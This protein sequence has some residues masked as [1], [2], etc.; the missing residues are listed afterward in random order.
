LD[1]PANDVAVIDLIDTPYDL[2]GRDIVCYPNL[3]LAF[4]IEIPRLFMQPRIV[5]STIT[6]DLVKGD[7]ARSDRF[8]ESHPIEI[9]QGAVVHQLT[10]TEAAIEAARKVVM[11]WLRHKYKIYKVPEI[12]LV[13]QH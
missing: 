11:R 10:S 8:P 5:Y 6:V 4:K 7:A 2:E 3:I 1:Q 13:K 12:E 9:R